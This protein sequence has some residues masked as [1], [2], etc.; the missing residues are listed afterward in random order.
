MDLSKIVGYCVSVVPSETE[1]LVQLF[2]QVDATLRVLKYDSFMPS[3]VGGYPTLGVDRAAALRGAINKFGSPCAIVDG[4]TCLT[5]TA[6]DRDGN[7]LGGVIM[8]GF[9]ASLAAMNEKAALLPPISMKQ[10]AEQYLYPAHEASAATTATAPEHNNTTAPLITLPTVPRLCKDT[11]TAMVSGVL[12]SLS[13]AIRDSI[14]N[15]QSVISSVPAAQ[16]PTN[17]RSTVVLCGGDSDALSLLLGGPGGAALIDE[18]DGS[19][20]SQG[21]GNASSSEQ[22]RLVVNRNIVHGGIAAVARG[23]LVFVGLTVAKDFGNAWGGVYEGSVT[24]WREEVVPATEVLGK[25]TRV[26][27]VDGRRVRD[28]FTIVYQD[29]DKEDVHYEELLPLLESRAKKELKDKEEKNKS[30][31]EAAA[32]VATSQDKKAAVKPVAVV[33]VAAVE[34]ETKADEVPAT[35][36][37]T[38]VVAT[39]KE[40]PKSKVGKRL[41]PITSENVTEESIEYGEYYVS[42][43]VAKFFG[44][45]L[46]QGKITKFVSPY[47]KVK[48]S[49]GDREEW[50]WFELKQGLQIF[51]QQKQLNEQDQA[52]KKKKLEC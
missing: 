28:L 46:F 47:W 52:K 10:V 4:G 8:P 45:A 18:D 27:E 25:D 26:R 43:E 49:D 22:H 15:W 7:L 39:K 50:E 48:Y 30:L 9:T 24:A 42:T 20:D 11:P 31:E 6:G 19:Y 41:P 5:F 29:G 51:E 16:S 35:Q 2:A 37:A 38:K 14:S 13:G 34:R 1:T 36:V 33:A 32:T 3:S 21:V 40:E 17:R 12:Y 23:P 44:G